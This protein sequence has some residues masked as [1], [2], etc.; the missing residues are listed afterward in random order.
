MFERPIV[1]FAMGAILGGLAAL[2]ISVGLMPFIVTLAFALVVAVA[3]RAHSVFAGVLCGFGL[4]WLVI[5]G[6]TY[7]NCVSM[8]PNCV[9]SEGMV[10]FLVIAGVVFL[11][12]VV[13]G[14]LGVV[15]DLE[16]RHGV[17]RGTP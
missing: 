11:S 17:R 1:K 2:T 16:T 7:T 8:G 14:L 9:G 15:R 4:T 12:G 10:P 3:W 5:I 13:V 6:S